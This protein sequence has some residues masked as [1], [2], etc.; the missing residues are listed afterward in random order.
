MAATQSAGH[1]MS[2]NLGA[3]AERLAR[4]ALVRGRAPVVLK[5]KKK[6]TKVPDSARLTMLELVLWYK[7]YSIN[8]IYNI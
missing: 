1:S 2:E 6:D 5:W 3:G 7:M 4:R 8:Y